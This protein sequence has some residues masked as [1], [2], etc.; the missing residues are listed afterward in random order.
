MERHHGCC[1]DNWSKS[2][3][4]QRREGR[5]RGASLPGAQARH[6]KQRVHAAEQAQSAPRRA[7]ASRQH[8]EARR[9]QHRTVRNA[10]AEVVQHCMAP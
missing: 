4:G 5:G 9:K 8:R 7:A 6:R 1:T 2:T 3:C 10:H